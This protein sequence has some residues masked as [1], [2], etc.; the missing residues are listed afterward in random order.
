MSRKTRGVL[1]THSGFL[2]LELFCASAFLL[3]LKRAQSGNTLSWAYVVE[4]PILGM[5]GIYMWQ[6]LLKEETHPAP[7]IR[8]SRTADQR[9]EEAALEAWN[10]YLAQVHASDPSDHEP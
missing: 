10:Q 3:E 5:Y 7:K 9:S 2:L 6:K 1:T 4:W 8:A